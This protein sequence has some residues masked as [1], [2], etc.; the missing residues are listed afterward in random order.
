MPVMVFIMELID[1]RDMIQFFIGIVIVFLRNVWLFA[2]A[3]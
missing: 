3:S 2:T 1:L